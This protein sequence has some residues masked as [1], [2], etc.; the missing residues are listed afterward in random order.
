MCTLRSSLMFV[1]VCVLFYMYM[2]VLSYLTWYVTYLMYGMR[3][4]TCIFNFY[5]H[6]LS[7]SLSLSPLL[8]SPFLF[9]LPNSLYTHT[10]SE[11][12]KFMS[13]P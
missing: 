1:V 8:F 5:S 2:Y 7:L 3:L 6:S 9:F 13:F 12:L 11:T 10:H 4:Y